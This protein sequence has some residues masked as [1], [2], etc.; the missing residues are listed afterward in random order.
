MLVAG[1]GVGV[2]IWLMRGAFLTLESGGG[3]LEQI[4][5]SSS[6]GS[7]AA[8]LFAAPAVL[9]LAHLLI[10]RTAMR[11]GAID[12]APFSREDVAWTAPLLLC[13]TSVLPLLL[14][15]LGVRVFSVVSFLIVDLRW[16]WTPLVFC[17]AGVGV[18][19]RLNGPVPTGVRPLWGLTSTSPWPRWRFAPEAAL[20]ALCALWVIASTP[21]LR[22][23]G[24]THG[25]E[26]KYLRYCENF[27]QGYGLEILE[28]SAHC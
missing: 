7:L 14:V 23:T 16:W 20:V 11:R 8:A 19:N 22:F 28:P 1:L 6:L 9:Y 5:V 26:P 25:D 12:L 18:Y 15:A 17:V 2:H 4:F 3:G 13:W 27:Y 24:G 21:N 10:R